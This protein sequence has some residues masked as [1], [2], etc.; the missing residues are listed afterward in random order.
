V[1]QGKLPV[2]FGIGGKMVLSSNLGVGIRI[3][4]G[5]AYLLESIPIDIFLELVPVLEL[6]PS[7]R[8]G[9]DGAIGIRYF[10]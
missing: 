5:I 7:T 8:I 6:L 1:D 3:P 9:F 4:F 10:F 2:Y